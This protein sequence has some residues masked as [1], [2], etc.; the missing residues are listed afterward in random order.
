MIRSGLVFFFKPRK[1]RGEIQS[2]PP[3]KKLNNNSRASSMHLRSFVSKI[4]ILNPR[5]RRQSRAEGSNACER[6]PPSGE[7]EAS[8]A[9]ASEE[10]RWAAGRATTP[11]RRPT[12]SPSSCL[13][14]PPQQN[15]TCRHFTPFIAAQHRR[16]GRRWGG[17]SLLFTPS[18]VFWEEG[19]RLGAHYT[20]ARVRAAHKRGRSGM[21]IPNA[22]ACAARALC[23]TSSPG[24]CLVDGLRPPRRPILRSWPQRAPRAPTVPHRSPPRGETPQP[25]R[26]AQA[27]DAA[28]PER[29]REGAD[30]F[31]F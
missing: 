3:Q 31:S 26:S 8:P 23:T 22:Y 5:T 12:P 2:P 1:R 20:Y 7:E 29:F 19:T 17:S 25:P 15:G 28:P 11:T 24:Q 30:V 6:S 21:W 14:P 18:C 16:R 27:V 10:P 4:A 13:Q 9:P